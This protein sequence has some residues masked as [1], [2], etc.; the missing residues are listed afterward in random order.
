MFLKLRPH[1]QSFLIRRVN[2]KLAARYFGPFKIIQKL[3][4]VVFKLDLPSSTKLH[5]VFHVSLLKKVMGDHQAL[6]DIP[7]ELIMDNVEF[8]P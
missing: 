1:R 2:Q 8:Q 6:K 7:A 3:S 5:P 4:E